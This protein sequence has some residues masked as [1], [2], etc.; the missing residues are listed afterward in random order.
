MDLCWQ[1]NGKV[2]LMLTTYLYNDIVQ[3]LEPGNYHLYYNQTADLI[4]I[5]RVH[6]FHV[7]DLNSGSHMH[8]DV[9]SPHSPAN[10]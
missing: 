4:L 6:L 5:P 2:I 9:L 10:L 1:S 7:S 3:Q 8:L